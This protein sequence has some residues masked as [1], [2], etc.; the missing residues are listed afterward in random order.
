MKTL[1]AAANKNTNKG[2]G[3]P[4]LSLSLSVSGK[5]LTHAVIIL[6]RSAD[7]ISKYVEQ[8]S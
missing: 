6:Q 3:P 7:R 5:D 1:T 8:T 2:S 4:T